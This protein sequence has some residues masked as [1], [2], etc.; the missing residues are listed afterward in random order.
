MRPDLAEVFT[1][2]R[3]GRAVS[4]FV[5]LD[6]HVY[7]E[8]VDVAQVHA[9]FID[10]LTAGVAGWIARTSPKRR[11]RQ[12]D[13]VRWIGRERVYLAEDR[14]VAEVYHVGVGGPLFATRA[15]AGEAA[16]LWRYGLSEEEREAQAA[17]PHV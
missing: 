4:R 17:L 12:E 13:L 10:G 11:S 9:S 7:A 8:G 6:F 2:Y 14:K 15:E 5:E 3:R 1:P 16:R